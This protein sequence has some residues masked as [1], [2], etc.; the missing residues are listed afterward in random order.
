MQI[1]GYPRETTPLLSERSDLIVFD[2]ITAPASLTGTSVPIMLTPATPK[3]PGLFFKYE[4]IL[5]L[6]NSAEFDTYWI[7]NQT[8]MVN[9][10]NE[11]AA[12][13][14]EATNRTYKNIGRAS[15]PDENLLPDLES[16]L[17]QQSKRKLIVLHLLGSHHYYKRRYPNSFDVFHNKPSTVKTDN[18][19]VINTIN[20]YDNSI[21]YTDYVTNRVI[22]ITSN[23]DIPSCVIYT[24]DHGEYLS[25]THRKNGHGYPD[26]ITPEA[27]IP[28]I[29]WCSKKYYQDHPSVKKTLLANHS[30][31]GAT[32]DLF[33]LLSDLMGIEFEIMDKKRS[34][35]SGEYTPHSVRFIKNPKGELDD[36]STLED[37]PH[38]MH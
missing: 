30:A 10:S 24:S 9:T 27:E 25:T 23:K 14:S 33:F 37:A 29:I 28:L 32:E 18:P 31:P 4:S 6:A 20:E 11:I 26:A 15:A 2:D 13:A 34:M 19:E 8:K 16:A 22:E 3:N 5:G 7:S 21:R 35:A 1:Y 17:S 36:V 12:L 38:F